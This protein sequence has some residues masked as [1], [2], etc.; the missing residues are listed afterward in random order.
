MHKFRIRFRN[1]QGTLLRMLLAVSRRGL[2]LPYVLA[3]PDGDMHELTLL[4]AANPKQMAQLGRDWRAIA[5]VIDV[6][7]P[8]PSGEAGGSSAA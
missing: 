7:Q 8:I 4:L 1:S 6:R 2:D 3:E 5:D